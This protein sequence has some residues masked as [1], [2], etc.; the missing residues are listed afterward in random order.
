MKLK[1]NSLLIGTVRGIP[2]RLHIS[3]LIAIGVFTLISRGSIIATLLFSLG[4]FGSV[5]LH[6]L[7]HS[8]VAQLKGAYIHEIILYPFGG[9]AKIANIPR[10]PIDE[11]LVAAAGPV[12]SLILAIA[13]YFIPGT[14]HLS[15]I[16]WMLFGFNALPV[17]P[18]DG[19]RILRAGL[20]TKRGRVEATR[21]AAEVGKYFCILFVIIGV[22][23]IN[24]S[25]FGEYL[26]M[27][28]NF[29]LAF[30]GFYIYN[31]GRNEY[32]MV[33]RE[34]VAENKTHKQQKNHLDIEV[35]PP[36]YAEQTV[37]EESLK[38]KLER[39]FKK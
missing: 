36:P 9:A 13:F 26:Y 38:E 3:L 4:L 19:G 16:N 27:E 6:E 37:K 12:V 2:I 14:E 10:K 34:A 20:A 15:H 11:M 8:I 1:K 39:L 5:A 18:M 23:G 29:V 28:K 17:F 32:Q 22:L 24:I 31:M 25:A 33:L 30:I 7:G 21:I 35:S